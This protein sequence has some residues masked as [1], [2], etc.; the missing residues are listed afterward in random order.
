MGSAGA[1]S[2][3]ATPGRPA[4]FLVAHRAGNDIHAV[5]HTSSATATLVEA[6]VRLRRD[7]LEVRHLKSAGPLPVL[8]DRWRL[9]PAWRH[10]TALRELLA[11]APPAITLILDL[12]GR[13]KRLAELV[14]AEIRPHLGTR[15]FAICA[16]DWRLLDVFRDLPVQRVHSVGSERQLRRLLDRYAGTRLHAVSIHE[17]LLDLD[18]VAALHDLAEV[19]MTWPVNR[20]E[21]ATEL[22]EMGVDGLITDDQER[23]EK[24][25]RRS[26]VFT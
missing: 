14:R 8:W 9:A 18:T 16:R 24:L 5:R 13:R 4:P 25:L 7:R 19:V 23:L 17:R 2:R 11:A 10:R 20:I 21:R 6:D 15:T 26:T 12:K 22:L 1:A 3:C